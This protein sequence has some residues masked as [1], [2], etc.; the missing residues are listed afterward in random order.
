VHST[1]QNRLAQRFWASWDETVD[2]QRKVADA[3]VIV[4]TVNSSHITPHSEAFQAVICFLVSHPEL[5]RRKQ[6]G[7]RQVIALGKAAVFF[8][9]DGVLNHASGSRGKPYRKDLAS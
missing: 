7:N 6:N 8:D 2:I 5:K 1:T 3:C 9:R 4:P